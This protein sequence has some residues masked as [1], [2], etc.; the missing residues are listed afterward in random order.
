MKV[1]RYDGTFELAFLR[2]DEAVRSDGFR[3]I[4]IIDAKT[5]DVHAT[6]QV[7]DVIVRNADGTLTVIR[8]LGELVEVAN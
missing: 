2:D 3:G 5:K 6:A 7:D 1:F 4:E 8:S